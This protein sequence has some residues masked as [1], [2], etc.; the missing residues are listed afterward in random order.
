MIVNSHI[1]TPAAKYDARALM[2]AHGHIR[3]YLAL[4]DAE[5]ARSVPDMAAVSAIRV[6]LTQA[7]R[8]RTEI[9]DELL[10]ACLRSGPGSVEAA[11]MQ[12]ELRRARLTSSAHISTWTS[13]TIAADWKGYC[14]ASAR[15]RDA[16]KR[17]IA[18]EA[19]LVERIAR[20]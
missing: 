1:Q 19:Q 4:L 3:T 6:K 20:A 9:L 13:R 11:T 18:A 10:A 5:T 14:A 15:L 7:S 17:Q 12:A 8:R 2:E 16:M